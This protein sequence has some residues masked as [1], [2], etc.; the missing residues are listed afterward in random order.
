V[1]AH[2]HALGAS[3]TLHRG[4][5]TARVTLPGTPWGDLD[6]RSSAVGDAAASSADSRAFRFALTG[7]A[8]RDHRSYPLR[9]T[10]DIVL[11]AASPLCL[12]L[13]DG[14]QRV[15]HGT[16]ARLIPVRRPGAAGTVIETIYALCC[17][18]GAPPGWVEV[19]MEHPADDASEAP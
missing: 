1:R 8:W 15:L 7:V 12:S 4:H 18:D 9:G 10:G 16:L 2:A 19:T 6:L 13:D 14:E 17:L 5:P 11:A 3:S